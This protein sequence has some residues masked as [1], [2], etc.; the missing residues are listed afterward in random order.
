MIDI[1]EIVEH[2]LKD[3]LKLIPFLF[4]AFLLLEYIEHKMSKKNQKI[5]IIE[6]GTVIVYGYTK[7]KVGESV[8][9][10][11]FTKKTTE[12]KGVEQKIN[13]SLSENFPFL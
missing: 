1:V 4:I 5:D 10:L 2:T 7:D 12:E 13:S 11:K 8:C 3:T 6:D 9:S